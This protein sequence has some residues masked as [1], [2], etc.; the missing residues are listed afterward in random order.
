MANDCRGI[1][2][3]LSERLAQGK[4]LLDSLV[5]RACIDVDGGGR[6][7]KQRLHVTHAFSSHCVQ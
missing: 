4:M 1:L 3:L 6:T 2:I 5:V 7:S